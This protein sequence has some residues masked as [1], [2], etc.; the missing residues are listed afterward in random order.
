MSDLTGFIPSP[1][2]GSGEPPDTRQGVRLVHFDGHRRCRLDRQ[3]TVGAARWRV[4][5]H[6]RCSIVGGPFGI[7]G[8]RLYHVT[9]DYSTYF[10]PNGLGFVAALKIW[11]AASESGV[12]SQV[13]RWVHGSP[14]AAQE[15]CSHRLRT[16]SRPALRLR[17]R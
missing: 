17:R 14:V 12:R 11:Q 9:T 5:L 3:S 4:R 1:S 13:G 7:V 16:R 8:A 10:G 6:H 15:C 2:S